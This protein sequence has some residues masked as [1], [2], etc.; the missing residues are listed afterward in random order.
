MDVLGRMAQPLLGQQTNGGPM[1]F[2]EPELLKSDC[3][4]DE[5]VELVSLCH[6]DTPLTS[7][8]PGQ[9]IRPGRYPAKDLP[10]SAFRLNLV[11]RLPLDEQPKPKATS[12]KTE[13]KPE[14]GEV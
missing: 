5:V 1:L 13:P 4:P 10:E 2:E 11:R 3:K 14:G 7:G 6:E 9:L 8:E 12:K